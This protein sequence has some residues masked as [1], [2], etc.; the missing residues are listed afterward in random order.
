MLF[1]GLEGV[2]SIRPIL[3]ELPDGVVPLYYPL[4]SE[5]R[6]SLQAMLRDE[7]IYAPIIWPFPDRMPSICKEAQTLYE[8]MICLPLDQRYDEDDMMRIVNCIRDSLK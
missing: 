3:G 6:N 7:Q 2:Y 8:H 1:D 5:D 4:F